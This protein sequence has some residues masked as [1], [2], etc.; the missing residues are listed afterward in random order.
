MGIDQPSAAVSASN[1]KAKLY[2]LITDKKE[3]GG[4]NGGAIVHD[5]E[6]SF[7]GMDDE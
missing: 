6:I 7:I 3:V 1:G 2:G 4:P 5:I